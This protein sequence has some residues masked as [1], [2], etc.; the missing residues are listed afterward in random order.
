MLAP[1]P[2]AARDPSPPHSIEAEQS[3]IGAVLINN[4]ALRAVDG[5]VAADD[6][7]EPVHAQLF[8]VA[9]Q[10]IGAGKRAT[11]IT[12]A[13]LM[14][15]GLVIA[16]MSLAQYLARLCAEA[17]TIINARDFAAVIREHAD[18]R[19]LNGVA[20]DIRQADNTIPASDLA[21]DAIEILDALVASRAET[22]TPPV[23]LGKAAYE[24]GE[25]LTLA[26]S[27]PGSMGGLT[28]GLKT[29]DGWIDGW[30]RQH[31]YVVGGRPSMGKTGAMI[32]SA[33]R[34]AEAG[35]AG[36]FFSLEMGSAALADRM[37]SD[38]I[39]SEPHSSVAYW[40]LQRGAVN[41]QQ[42]AAVVEA[43]RDLQQ[44]D[45]PLL[46]EPTAGL[47]VSQIAART[48]RHAQALERKGGRLAF[49][50]VDHV[51]IIRPNDR[52]RGNRTAE[53]TEISG[54]LKALAKE[55]DIAVIAL[56]QLSRGLESREDR[57]PTMADL[58]DSG[59]IEQDADAIIFLFRE[60]YYLTR[61]QGATAEAED[62]RVARLAEVRNILELIVAKQRSGPTGPLKVFFHAPSNAL[63]DL[64]EVR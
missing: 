22:S 60:E 29:L 27:R 59:S 58:R 62:R 32:S 51:H 9:A 5:R 10:L 34:T 19:L 54:G 63:R 37:I 26:R 57:R 24:A 16:G 3:L 50:M 55:L 47:T 45:Y 20:G 52:Y 12:M 28:T 8:E 14:P 40:D 48:R 46:I 38:R 21:S 43:I 33:R 11:P 44:Q 7:F 56:A 31:F 6:F 61:T 4:D 23:S 30:Q 49:I 15:A 36:I 64:A 18:R 17:T 13:P 25:R 42:A 2:E 41:D 35:H 1:N 53:V 39:F